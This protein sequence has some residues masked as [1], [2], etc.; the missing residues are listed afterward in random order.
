MPSG[1]SCGH[2]AGAAAP[3]ATR[4]RGPSVP[5]GYRLGPRSLGFGSVPTGCDLG[6]G[7]PL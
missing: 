7:D 5:H 2:A 4:Q 3:S 1:L 6:G